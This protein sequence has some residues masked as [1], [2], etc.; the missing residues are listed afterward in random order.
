MDNASEVTIVNYVGV[1]CIIIKRAI[2]N[3]CREQQYLQQNTFRRYHS[4]EEY[5]SKFIWWVLGK[6]KGRNYALNGNRQRELSRFPQGNWSLSVLKMQT[7]KG[8][9]V[10]ESFRPSVLRKKLALC[11][12]LSVLMASTVTIFN[13]IAIVE[14]DQNNLFK[15]VN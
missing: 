13:L 8:H 11:R 15:L 6:W 3:Y 4:W 2:N 10:Q 14:Q 9:A 7:S 1:E 5:Y 12:L